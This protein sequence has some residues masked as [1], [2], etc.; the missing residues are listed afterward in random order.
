[1]T[2][3]A[4]AASPIRA[5]RHARGFTLLEVLMVLG[6]ILILASLVLGVGSALLKN[7]EKSQMQSAFVS[8]ES[9]IN[10]WEAQT[11]RPVTYNGA[12]NAAGT[13]EVFPSGSSLEMFDIWES[14]SAPPAPNNTGNRLTFTR[15]RGLGVYTVNLLGQLDSIRPILAGIP[16][17]L[18]RPEPNA[19]TFPAA[20]VTTNGVLYSP[21][22]RSA[23]NGKD[24]TRSEFVDPWGNRIAFV[25][26]GRAYRYGVDSGV[27]DPDGT[28][29]TPLE[30][31]APG[32]GVCTNRRICLVSAGPDGLFGVAGETTPDTAVARATAAADNI[33][34]Y[35]LDPPN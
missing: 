10:E 16:P 24:S 11:G 26:P 18:L 5:P 19:V 20:N 35:E 4:P 12:F 28:V 3:P 13:A 14:S 34:L 30:N 27:P 33:Y 23:M 2:A 7:A 25:F 31:L 6:V 32:F 22:A 9:A 21:S 1:V 17:T 29:R 8:V 15:A